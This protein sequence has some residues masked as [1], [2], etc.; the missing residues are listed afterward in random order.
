[1]KAALVSF[2]VMVAVCAVIP[3]PASAQLVLY[4]NFEASLLDPGRW[5][6]AESSGPGIGILESR[7]QIKN[8]PITGFRGLNIFTRSFASSESNDTGRLSSSDRL[9]FNDGSLIKTIRATV[10]V[11]KFEETTCATNTS[12]T[13]PRVRI[14]GFFFNTGVSTPGDATNDVQAYII[15]GRPTDATDLA[16]DE[17]KIYAK[18][19]L[20]NDADCDD[21]TEIGSQNIATVEVNK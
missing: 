8:E 6:G 9:I 12:A 1:M 20:C 10:L 13:E 17:L 14:G 4:D 16:A 11:K 2:L 3:I 19:N 21:S 7:R 18:V 15:V 5:F